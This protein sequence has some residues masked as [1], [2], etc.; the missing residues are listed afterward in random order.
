MRHKSNGFWAFH[1]NDYV[2]S[3]KY[4]AQNYYLLWVAFTCLQWVNKTQI[5]YQIS[6]NPWQVIISGP[7]YPTSRL[8]ASNPPPVAARGAKTGSDFPCPSR[9]AAFNHHSPHS[10][11]SPTVYLSQRLSSKIQKRVTWTMHIQKLLSC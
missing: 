8:A 5:N 7:V 3:R 2:K 1:Q 6:R 10:L 11:T 4:W 9:F